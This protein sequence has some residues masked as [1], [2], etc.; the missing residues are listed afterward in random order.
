[1]ENSS[2]SS[3]EVFG[4][5][6]QKLSLKKKQQSGVIKYCF[7][8]NNYKS[9]DIDNIEILLKKFCNKYM[10]QAEV[11][12]SGTKHLQGAIW[13]KQ[14]MRITQFKDWEYLNKAHWEAMVNEEA[15]IIYCSK[16]GTDGYDQEVKIKRIYGFPKAVKIID[17]LYPWQLDIEKRNMIEP[18]GR[19]INWI[20][21]QEGNVGKSAFCKYMYV[22]HNVLVIQGGKLADIMNIIFNTDMDKVTSLFID[23]PRN[24][25]NNISYNAIECILNGMIT[26]TKYETGIK[27]FNPPNIFVFSNY[28]PETAGLS[29]DRWQI[30]EIRDKILIKKYIEI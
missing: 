11:G 17:A 30:F 18:D 25:K 5:T 21:E 22:K 8:L 19:T 13:L 16:G 15:S 28:P 29:H 23:I 9:E 26:N 12:A 27:V 3:K 4:N 14:K 6:E 1:M 10:F 20:Y 7:T 2:N 24:N